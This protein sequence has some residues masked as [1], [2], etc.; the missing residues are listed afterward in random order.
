MKTS[1]A[2]QTRRTLLAKGRLSWSLVP[3]ILCCFL[4]FHSL[5][6]GTALAAD[7]GRLQWHY[8]SSATGE[9]PPPG[10]GTQQTCAVVF[11]INGDGLNDF[12][13]TERTQAPAVVWYER[14]AQGWLRH[15]LEPKALRIEAGCTYADVDADGDFD[16]VAGGDARSHEVW[17]WENPMPA[18]SPADRWPR[19]VIKDWGATKHHDLLFGD[20]DGDGRQELVF[21]NQK[22]RKLYFCEIPVPPQRS[23]WP[24]RAIYSYGGDSEPLQRGRPA[25]FKGVNEHEGLAAADIDGDGQLDVV[26]GGRWFRRTRE[27]KF[28]VNLIDPAYAFTRVAVG[29]LKQGGR[30]EVV[31]V[32]GDG[33]GPLIWYEW[34][35][36]TWIPH[37][38]G[39]VENGHTLQVV[40]F[41]GDGHLDIFCA[42]MR[43]RG[44]NADA[45]VYL[46]RGDGAGHFK[47]LILLKGFG[48]HESKVADLNG[49]GKLDIL[50]KPYNWQTPRVDIWLQR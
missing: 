5:T 38:L 50:G 46:F 16:F 49:D 15:V 37:Q 41:D 42:E 12:V 27:G 24:C 28:E 39:E 30:P 36:G 17:W 22:G 3:A 40:D 35:R 1:G 44:G 2:L 7:S 21:W 23:P 48:F 18:R 8:L 9:I 31:M 20:F 29:Q 33:E 34:V 19:R 11:D 32:V 45:R 4:A 43:L 25:P 47:K 14:T 10:K 26:G 6:A 13:I